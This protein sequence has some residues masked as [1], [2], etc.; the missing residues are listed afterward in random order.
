MDAVTETYRVTGAFPQKETYGLQAQMRRAAVSVPSNIAEG[1]A[2][3]LR[4]SLNHLSIAL[5]SLAELDTQLEV[6]VRL[7]YLTAA[8]AADL[9]RLL[10]SSRRLVHGLRRAKQLRLGG[11]V[12]TSAVLLFLMVTKVLT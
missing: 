6:A 3:Q 4:A 5:G 1:Q 2:R 10:I 7:S 8:S 12:A 11:A 9:N